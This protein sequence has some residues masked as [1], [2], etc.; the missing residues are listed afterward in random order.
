MMEMFNVFI[1]VSDGSSVFRWIVCE[2]G[3]SIP[4]RDPSVGQG[5]FE[6]ALVK[7]NPWFIGIINCNTSR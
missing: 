4:R 3:F 7:C 2:Q 6:A 1:T 5:G